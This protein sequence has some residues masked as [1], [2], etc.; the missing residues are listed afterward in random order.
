MNKKIAVI[1]FNLGGPDS[2]SAVKPFLFNLFYDPAII[3]LINPFR[4]LLAK[5]I[6]SKREKDAIEIYAKMGGASTILPI[7]NKQAELLE[8]KLNTKSKDQFKV[9]VS[10]RYWHPFAKEILAKVK[11]FEADEVLLLPLYPQFSTTTTKSSLDEFSKMI[12]AKTV[13]CYYKDPEFIKAHVEMIKAKLP[14]GKYRIL[15]SAHGLPEYIVKNGDP[16]QW[17][18][19]QSVQ[20][21]MEKLGSKIDHVICYQSK[22]G[23]LKWLEPS[24]EEEIKKAAAENIAVVIVPIAFVSDHSETLV[25]LDLEYKDVFQSKCKKAYI[26]IDALNYNENY[27]QALFNQVK[28]MT[29]GKAIRCNGNLEIFA[30]N[31]CLTNL[32]DCPCHKN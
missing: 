6:S 28:L 15:F 9:F 25:E 13:C 23:K 1:L 16:Y 27:T 17:Q 11:E 7:T 2:L 21:I 14:K 26:R 22:V 4:W 32:K 3:R 10:M 12:K 31:K 29:E 18:I 24:T 8:N 20:G 19:E 5:F 30:Q